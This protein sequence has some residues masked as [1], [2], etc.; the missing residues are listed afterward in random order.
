[1]SDRPFSPGEALAGRT[2]LLCGGTGFLGKVF[3]S[4]L[5]DRFPEIGH[6]YLLV[7]SAGDARRR[8]HEEVLP[9]PAFD[10]LRRRHGPHLSAYLEEKLSVVAGD[11]AEPGLGLDET[12]AAAVAAR[13]DVVVNVAAHVVFDA[14]LDSALRANVSGPRHALAFARLLRRPAL[15]HVS[16]CY[17]AGDRHGERWE[18]EPIA[19]SYPSR[20]EG[21]PELCVESEI[22]ECVRALGR[23][24]EESEDQALAARF[25]AAARRRLR[26]EGR[27][28][29]RQR[30]RAAA[31]LERKAWLRR[32]LVELGA[33]RARRWGWPNVYVYTKSLGEQ[34]VASAADVVRSIV[35]PAIIESALSFP[36][37]G[38]NEGFTTTAPVIQLVFRGQSHF[39][40]RAD[41]ILDVVPV[42]AVASALA[43]VTAEV[44]ATEPP[45]VYQLSTSDTNP[46]PLA[47]ATELL[48]IYRRRRARRPGAPLGDKIAARV[49]IRTMDPDLFEGAVLPAVKAAARG[50]ARAM[51][52]LE[53]AGLG[54]SGWARRAKAAVAAFQDE[55]ASGEGHV[56][57]FRPYM[58]D[59][60]Y[61]FR[62]DNVRALF[63]RIR[64][65]ERDR[66]QWAP[67]RIDW[68]D[69]WVN[70]HC[71]GLERWVL[72]RLDRPN[73]PRRRPTYRSLV[74]L[75]EGATR[76]HA[77]RVAMVL[78]T[79]SGVKRYRYRDLREGALRVAAS[80]AARGVGSGD[81]VALLAPNSPQWGMAYFGI[82]RCGAAAVPLAAE[83]AP[84]ELTDLLS[85]SDATTLLLGE[86]SLR[87]ATVRAIDDMGLAV[88]VVTLDE[89]LGPREAV[90]EEELVA[91]LPPPPP[92]DALAS[93]LFTSG[94][95]GTPRGV[96]LTHRN[97]TSQVAQLL[98]VYDLDTRDGMLS[99]LPLHHSFEFSAGFLLP[100]S[101][102]ARITYLAEVS[103]ETIAAALRSGHVTCMVGVPAVWD[104]L[105]RRV[106]GRLA[107]RSPR[108]GAL[109]ARLSALNRRL[110][111]E[112]PL[113]LGPLLF[114]PVHLGL[115]GRIRYLISGG[116][117]LSRETLE[118]FRG[119]GFELLEGYG[120]T[121]AAPVLAVSRPGE[122]PAPG[123][124]GRPLP[125]VELRI[126][127]P[128]GAGVGEVMARGPGIMAGYYKDAAATAEA[129]EGGWLRTGDLGRL[130]D[131]G[132][133]RLSGRLKEIIVGPEGENVHP[134]E[135]E[136][137]YAAPGL[138]KEL[139]VLG[140]R[141]PAG[142]ERVAALA[143]PDLAALTSLDA[144]QRRARVEDHFRRVSANLPPHQRVRVLHVLE[145]ELPRTK[146]RKIKRRDVAV[147]LAGFE[148]APAPAS[149]PAADTAWLKAL[150]AP[151]L[152]RPERELPDHLSLDGLGL[153]S[154]GYAELSAAL[155][156]AGHEG[157]PP[158]VLSAF[159]D[160]R[161]MA[162]ALDG[163]AGG[164]AAPP[165]PEESGREIH[166]PK[167]VS[168]LGRRGYLLAERLVY[169][170]LLRSRVRG[171]RHVPARG[172][173][174]VAANHLSHLDA[175]LVRTALG[176]A[177]DRL[178]VL[179]AADYFFDTPLKRAF[180]SSF[181]GLLPLERGVTSVASLRRAL[182][183]LE[184][185]LSV[186]VFPEGT[187]SR[188]GA[189]Q[190][191]RRGVGTLA[192]RAGVGVLPVRVDTHAALPPGSMALR[193][194]RVEAH[195]GPFLPYGVLARAAEGLP[196]PEAERAAASLVREA[197]ER[198]Q[199]GSAR[200][201]STRSGRHPSHELAEV[202]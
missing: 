56:K 114:A 202:E 106:M 32:R 35:R 104:L 194:R 150:I 40:G 200:R 78:R 87:P 171:R 23:A 61:V 197:V 137:R 119:L 46:L 67:E 3:T 33:E 111:D 116:A 76:T 24:R 7:R 31:T 190:P 83:T 84:G 65:P 103:G 135:L 29:D 108:L 20:Q 177:G 123:T 63:R 25:L 62:T 147:L 126:D 143:V 52:R 43:A 115:G 139:C 73:R 105:G 160:L 195:I 140:W 37:P 91:R 86:P 88:E 109:A 182:E 68:A 21:D 97:F 181:A 17:V 48:E 28:P 133:L 128:D 60:C 15:V 158:D 93:I 188:S 162:A 155:Q 132:R 1:M 154:L 10:P 38:W 102:G 179:A 136:R 44:V 174:I 55:V 12:E 72:G 148:R 42:D 157:L 146:T 129:L 167:I 75:F 57:T 131:T 79:P 6:L 13:C 193:S 80:L 54:L 118:T 122:R 186:L 144:A 183:S 151:L 9:S 99:L 110:R 192:L 191:F 30:E 153:D 26:E 142:A 112:T 201:G 18:D 176:P 4:L 125:G 165:E 130:D 141:D 71:P 161:A 36:H 184:S 124:V 27:P 53:A 5:L 85:R 2:I 168:A 196:R 45:L 69:Y 107:K 199:N 120:L 95:M 101:R 180:F 81:K 134:D 138:V 16:T 51:D 149:A 39:P 14:P 169:E 164:V 77:S 8:F 19:G 92:P 96:M 175:G 117:A 178:V 89:L 189:L 74:E 41:V 185:G 170:G 47:R 100:L 82:V 152:G 70:V 22:A 58:A 94:S 98:A 121:E 64:G 163:G 59:N 173:Y 34:L 159:S 198:L 50:T 156:A 11:V 127:R 187:R 145:G 49:A 113:N 166:V 90:G 66:V 172:P